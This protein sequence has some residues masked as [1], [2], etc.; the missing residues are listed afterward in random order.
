VRKRRDNEG[1][2]VRDKGFSTYSAAIESAAARSTDD[3]PFAQ[4]VI[5]EATRRG[6]DKAK[7][8]VVLGD[9]AHW[10]WNLLGEYFPGAIEIVDRFHASQ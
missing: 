5:R 10:I 9:G 2:P 7:R 8:R 4:R 1:R 6:F 3:A